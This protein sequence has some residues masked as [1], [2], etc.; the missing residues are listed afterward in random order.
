VS[1]AVVCSSPVGFV[2]SMNQ[3]RLIVASLLINGCSLFLSLYN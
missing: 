2:A 3:N 1:V